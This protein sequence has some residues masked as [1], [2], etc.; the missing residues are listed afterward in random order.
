MLSE[1]RLAAAG[2]VVRALSGSYQS[3]GLY[4]IGHPERL[5]HARTTVEVASQLLT[6]PDGEHPTLFIARGGFYLGTTLLPRESLGLGRFAQAV[7][8]AGIESITITPAVEPAD[9]DA[10]AEA[11]RDGSPTGTE[12]GGLRINVIRPIVREEEPWEERLG[13]LRRAYAGGVTALRTASQQAAAGETVDLSATQ[14]IVEQLY[15]QLTVD[16]GYGLLLSAVK[17][18]DEYTYFHMVNVCLLSVALG[19]AIGL[20]RDQVLVLGLGGLLHDIGK[21]FV[22]AE[23][24]T[25]TG[26]LDEE[27]WRL[28][29]RHPVDGAG[30]LLSTGSGLVH[31]AASVL[32]EH[33]AAYD[34]SGY[35]GLHGHQPS[36][37]SRLV[38]VADCFDAVTSKRTY[39]QPLDRREALQVLTSA[40]GTGLDPRAV[41]AFQGLLGRFPIGSLVELSTGEVGVVVR[42]HGELPTHPVVLELFDATGTPVEV[43]ERDLSA[44]RPS[45]PKVVR[46]RNPEQLGVDLPRFVASGQLHSLPGQADQPGSS[47]GL[48]HEPVPGEQEPEG[49]VDTHNEP[50]GHGHSHEHPHGHAGGE[51]LTVDDEVAPPFGHRT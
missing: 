22:P 41:A 39:R 34:G 38:A 35:P 24:L 50:G 47:G 31:P 2:H 36:V 32:L 10:L 43:R 7:E 44:E 29:Q 48:V 9:V 37:P 19:Q 11:I 8:D 42:Q 1:D 15:D 5:E 23:I 18:Y 28:V 49:Y 33:H 30:V 46:Q 21:V 45:G 27:Q 25:G 51:G 20:R 26:R 14:G 40:A 4:P 16:P 17:S 3:A 13:E 12:L 6:A